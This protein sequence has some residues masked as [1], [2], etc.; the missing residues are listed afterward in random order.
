MSK[1]RILTLL[2]STKQESINKQILGYV[3]AQLSDQYEVDGFDLTALPYFN[4][5]LDTDTH[6]PE[7]VQSFR[8]AMARAQGVLICT[9]EYVFTIPGVLKNALEWLVST[10]VLDQKPTAVITAA[11]S[12]TMAHESLLLV[13][14]TIGAHI[15]DTSALLISAPKTKFDVNG[16]PTDA[17]TATEIQRLIQDFTISLKGAHVT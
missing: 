9:P 11:S 2:G 13:L 10:M 3:T 8:T 12:G 1:P 4:P 16:L 7:S 14:K 15:G 6:T 5:S 17:H